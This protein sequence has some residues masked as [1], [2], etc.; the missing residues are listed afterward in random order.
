MVGM[1]HGEGE[2]TGTDPVASAR[3]P[4]PA[5]APGFFALG[6]LPGDFELAVT[7]QAVLVPPPQHK[8]GGVMIQRAQPQAAGVAAIKD[9]QHL[10]LPTATRPLQQ[11]LVLIAGPTGS[12][13]AA[14]PPAQGGEHG[15][16]LAQ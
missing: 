8:A 4:E 5:T 16:A 10:A 11:F 2:H 9:M 12:P 13:A 1:A 6:N 15:R 7:E 14:A 3:I